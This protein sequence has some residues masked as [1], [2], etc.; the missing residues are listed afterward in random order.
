MIDKLPTTCRERQ[1]GQSYLV[2]EVAGRRS[3][4]PVSPAADDE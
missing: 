3:Y 1:V 2:T 4:P